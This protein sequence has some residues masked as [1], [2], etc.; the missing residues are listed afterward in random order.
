MFNILQVL[1]MSCAEYDRSRPLF[2]RDNV[3]CEFLSLVVGNK[4]NNN[5]TNNNNNISNNSIATSKRIVPCTL[6]LL[7]GRR[8]CAQ[9]QRE[10]RVIRFEVSDECSSVVIQHDSAPTGNGDSIATSTTSSALTHNV[11]TL[12]RTP[13][14]HDATYINTNDNRRP[15]PMMQLQHTF[16]QEVTSS[17]RDGSIIKTPMGDISKTPSG[18]STAS[19]YHKFCLMGPIR[20]FELEVGESDFVELRRDQALL[21]DFHNFAHSFVSLLGYCD[22]GETNQSQRP[23]TETDMHTGP[24]GNIISNT[25]NSTSRNPFSPNSISDASSSRYTCRIEDYGNGTAISST[26]TTRSNNGYHSASNGKIGARFMVVES[27]Q[28]RELTHLSL[29]LQVGTDSSIRLYLSTRLGQLMSENHYLR[30]FLQ[31]ETKRAEMAEDLFQQMDAKFHNLTVTSDAEIRETRVQLTDQMQEAIMKQNNKYTC[32]LHEKE[33]M[34]RSL[35]ETMEMKLQRMEE[36]FKAE[37]S[38]AC[39]LRN[40]NNSLNNMN[41]ELRKTLETREATI[42]ELLFDLTFSKSKIQQLEQDKDTVDKRLHE[43]QVRIVA[44]EKSIEGKENVLLQ[45]DVYREATDKASAQASENLHIY[46]TQLEE[47]RTQLATVTNEM[48]KVTDL[49]MQL[50]KDKKEYK[51]KLKLRA[52]VIKRQEE[53]LCEKD[54]LLSNFEKKLNKLVMERDKIKKVECANRHEL[55]AT[56]TKLAESIKNLEKNKHV[57]IS[58]LERIHKLYFFDRYPKH[59]VTFYLPLTGYHFLEKGAE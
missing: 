43:A 19:V 40:E 33:G 42:K 56:K 28:F 17:T 16:Q 50:Q 6:R 31:S 22:L 46:K 21:V 38:Y 36:K 3:P 52:K 57:S 2:E 5:N 23:Y 8:R 44:L 34:L 48:I 51:L 35:K 12:D 18:G 10:E 14:T 26:L 15:I 39:E 41:E 25:N 4:N 27:N 30:S 47:S 13:S 54:T 32:M 1:T 49:N 20:L 11:P 29:N 53:V 37:E 58:L 55:E 7:E 45:A 24:L 9:T 59:Y